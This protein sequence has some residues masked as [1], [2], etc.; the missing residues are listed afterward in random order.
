MYLKTNHNYEMDVNHRNFPIHLLFFSQYVYPESWIITE[1]DIKNFFK[2]FLIPFYTISIFIYDWK[3]N[4]II[5]SIIPFV[6]IN[7][8]KFVWM[9]I[10]TLCFFMYYC[11]ERN[12]DIIFFCWNKINWWNLKRKI[13]SKK[14]EWWN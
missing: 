13:V 12:T 4:N 7:T 2:I 6:I 8:F 9:Y 5:G 11:C 10:L 1:N 3:P 14:F